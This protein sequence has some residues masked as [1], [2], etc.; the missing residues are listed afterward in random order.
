MEQVLVSQVMEYQAEHT[1][2]VHCI[3][4]S[5]ITNNFHI[6]QIIAPGVV[7]IIDVVSIS[8]SAS[9]V[10][11]SPPIEPNGIITGYE[12]VYSVYGIDAE[13]VVGSLDSDINILNITDLS[14][15]CLEF[16]CDVC[17]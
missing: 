4:T 15:L 8:T 1:K 17:M 9:V 14:K 7:E 5:I 10:T 13:S 2:Q 3:C 6:P 12:V 11:W 16:I